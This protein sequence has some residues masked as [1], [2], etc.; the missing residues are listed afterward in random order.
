VIPLAGRFR[1]GPERGHLLVRTGREGLAARAGHDLT[2]EVTRWS[3]QCAIPDG[4]IATASLTAYMDLSSLVVRDG[5]GGALPLRARDR[6]DIEM[7]ARKML[8]TGPD[9]TATFTSTRVD[10]DASGAT[11]DGYLTL[12]GRAAPI[13]ITISRTALDR[14]LGTATVIQSAHGLRP[15]VGFFGA[16]RMRD[17][18][19]VEVDVRLPQSMP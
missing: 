4:D 16:L 15:Y 18:V 9:S 19:A 5:S 11:V 10:G 7:N 12:H 13:R 8:G 3:A 17:G 14:Y 1:L 2:L 6:R